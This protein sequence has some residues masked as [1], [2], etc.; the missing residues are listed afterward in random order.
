MAENF[1]K[2]LVV[3][4]D[5]TMREVCSEVLASEGYDVSVAAGGWEALGLIGLKWDLIITDFNMPGLDGAGFYEAAVSRIPEISDKFIFMTGDMASARVIE[6]MNGRL[7]KKPFRV[8]DLLN[9]VESILKESEPSRRYRRV[10]LEGC[11]LHI[12]FDGSEL[13]AV[14]EDLSLHGMKIKYQGRPFEAGPGLKVSIDNLNISRDARVVWSVASA[15]ESFSGI[16]FEKPV[17]ASVFAEL[18]PCSL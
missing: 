2:I 6:K 8:R 5:E 11:A 7:V 15:S 3:D 14:A 13:A 4:D 18:V 10:R 1:F 9:A 16:I 17:P 12:R